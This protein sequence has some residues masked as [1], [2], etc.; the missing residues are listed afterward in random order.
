MLLLKFIK[1]TMA[2][3]NDLYINRRTSNPIFNA[4]FCDL[5]PNF[6]C[7]YEDEEDNNECMYAHG[8]SLYSLVQACK[9]TN[10][11]FAPGEVLREYNVPITSGEN[12]ATTKLN[13][14][15]VSVINAVPAYFGQIRGAQI[16]AN[17]AN[18]SSE[19]DL[20]SNI[21]CKRVIIVF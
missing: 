3:K 20:L 1:K 16:Y 14:K 4:K 15:Y 13:Y 7:A 5:Y 2:Y 19:E 21:K 12:F 10:A 11:Q 8:T 18:T 9:H 17:M 6:G